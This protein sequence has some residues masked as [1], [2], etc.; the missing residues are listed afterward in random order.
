VS[1]LL[2][3]LG[4]GLAQLMSQLWTLVVLVL[5]LG[6]PPATTD[7]SAALVGSRR[8]IDPTAHAVAC[9]CSLR[10]PSVSS[11]AA[12]SGSERVA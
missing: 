3:F 1:T 9:I 7:V 5:E 10:A 2:G 11:K 4:V 12:S 8:H 6:A